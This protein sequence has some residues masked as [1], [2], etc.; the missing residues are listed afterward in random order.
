M[1]DKGFTVMV[2]MN[3][4]E[5]PS[6]HLYWALFCISILTVDIGNDACVFSRVSVNFLI[7]IL[8]VS[9]CIL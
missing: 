7:A 4:C 2:C 6:D 5:I 9:A 3:E 8:T 1:N